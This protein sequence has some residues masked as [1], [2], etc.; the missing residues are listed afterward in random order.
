MS[1]SWL[2][3]ALVQTTPASAQQFNL[4]CTGTQQ[5]IE[6]ELLSNETTPFKRTFRV[7]LQ[8]KKIC[9]DSCPDIAD[10]FSVTDEAIILEESVTE[11]AP[12]QA[13]KINQINRKNGAYSM[14]YSK[15]GSML[16]V[17]AVCEVR[18][19]TGLPEIKT[20]F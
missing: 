5:V 19:F 10:L 12:G 16:N 4:E 9:A 14:L 15:R 6:Q 2:A 20:L 8:K 11:P 3:L 1:A 7:D 13:M 17:K 18:K